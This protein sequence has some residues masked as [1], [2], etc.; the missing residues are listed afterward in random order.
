MFQN[1][2]PTPSP[3]HGLSIADVRGK[4]IIL[5]GDNNVGRLDDVSNAYLLDSC[6][7]TFFYTHNH[8]IYIYRRIRNNMNGKLNILYFFSFSK[9]SLPT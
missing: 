4:M 1:M 9:N 7:Y 3:R 2:G 5:G 6:T 8:Y